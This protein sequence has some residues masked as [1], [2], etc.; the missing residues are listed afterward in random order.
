VLRTPIT[1][2][3]AA[4][5][6]ALL[7][8]CGPVQMGA[9]ATVGSTGISATTL[10][11]E[12]K[13]L[14]QAIAASHGRIQLQ[15]P[16]ARTPQAVLSWLIRFQVQDR[17]AARRHITVVTR[18]DIQKALREASAQARQSGVTFAALAAANGLPPD[19]L[20]AYGRYRAIGNKLVGQLDQG[21]LPTSQSGLQALSKEFGTL[22][23]RAAKSLNIQVNPQF[24]Q[25][26]YTQLAV[27][28]AASALSAPEGGR[29]GQGAQPG[30]AC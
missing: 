13:N 9:A 22:Q 20:N 27:V 21:S 29:A 1:V 17:L 15:F 4:A 19:L 28:P 18:A 30:P 25:L 3:A 11:S 23:C 7:T 10:N 14:D 8:A 26:S 6:L 2:T 24:G 5:A 12:V 16:A